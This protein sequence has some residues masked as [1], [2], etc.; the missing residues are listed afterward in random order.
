VAFRIWYGIVRRYKVTSVAVYWFLIGIW[1][2]GL[3]VIILGE[4]LTL[5]HGVGFSLVVAALV[6]MYRG[7]ENASRVTATIPQQPVIS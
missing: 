7:K 5:N 6:L 4:P 3:S 1:G 2:A